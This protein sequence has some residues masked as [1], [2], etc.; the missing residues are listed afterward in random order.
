MVWS[1]LSLIVYF[2]TQVACP[3]LLTPSF[4]IKQWRKGW[5][6]FRIAFHRG[7]WY[8]IKAL[9]EKYLLTILL[10]TFFYLLSQCLTMN[11]SKISSLS[12]YK[13]WIAPVRDRH[14]S[15]KSDLHN[16]VGKQSWCVQSIYSQP[17]IPTLYLLSFLF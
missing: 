2:S 10:S 6:I 17:L 9:S 16:L 11:F 5:I 13:L 3:Y 12:T 14:P 1:V 15:G 8:N 4:S 7:C